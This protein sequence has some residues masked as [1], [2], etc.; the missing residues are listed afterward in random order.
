MYDPILNNQ[1]DDDI[2]DDNKTL[3]D[4][5]SNSDNRKKSFDS[6][7]DSFHGSFNEESTGDDR[8]ERFL[9]LFSS[10]NPDA[11]ANVRFHLVDGF[12]ESVTKWLFEYQVDETSHGTYAYLSSLEDKNFPLYHRYYELEMEILKKHIL[13][14]FLEDTFLNEK[15]LKL[16][17]KL[18]NIFKSNVDERYIITYFQSLYDIMRF[19]IIQ[20]IGF[21]KAL[22][23]KLNLETVDSV[24]DGTGSVV[25]LSSSSRKNVLLAKL[26]D[27]DLKKSIADFIN[28]EMK[29]NGF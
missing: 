17:Q 7:N 12:Y 8:T 15:S 24:I 18:N 21:Y 20:E 13:C 28:K 4:I 22:S 26:I 27:D 10:E 11:V 25:S 2:F 9:K 6:I 19:T 14:G 5:N 3:K 23:K 29:Q 16:F 1:N